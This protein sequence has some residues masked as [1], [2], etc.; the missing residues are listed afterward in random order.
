MSRMQ[1]NLVA[2]N[3]A[4]ARQMIRSSKAMTRATIKS[5]IAKQASQSAFCGTPGV[6]D[7]GDCT[8]YNPPE[9]AGF[10]GSIIAMKGGTTLV[11]P[12]TCAGA[13]VATV[14]PDHYLGGHLDTSLGCPEDGDVVMWRAGTGDKP[15]RWVSASLQEAFARACLQLPDSL[16]EVDCAAAL[17]DALNKKKGIAARSIR[18]SA[19][20]V[21]LPA[22]ET[23]PQST[24]A[25][26]T[27]GNGEDGDLVLQ[28]NSELIKDMYFRNLNLN[29][30]TLFTN[31]FRLFV[32]GSLSAG[33]SAS[34][35]PGTLSA[36]GN[37]GSAE[38]VGAAT[39]LGTVGQG[40]AGNDSIEYSLAGSAGSRGDGSLGPKAALVPDEEGG[41]NLM[42]ELESALR[43]RAL[44]GKRLNGG[45]GGVGPHAGGGGGVLFVVAR[46]TLIAGILQARGGA[47]GAADSG[48]GGGGVVVF[49]HSDS[50]KWAVDVS[51][52]DRSAESG[53][54]FSIRA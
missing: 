13:G 49:I 45:A 54:S 23:L 16:G 26:R 41:L 4:F 47:A 31:G 15:G 21:A 34:G 42:N 35:R 24:E 17:E 37:A 2:R 6:G 44:D 19:R 12:S 18:R 8:L 28:E 27:F 7:P 11:D 1:A 53:R 3:K 46:A 38:A 51:G 5:G 52:G 14:P 48:A 33:R 9:E 39:P 22:V 29:G 25:S 30:F 40:A 36:D 43:M 10:P 50:Q 20:S 32:N